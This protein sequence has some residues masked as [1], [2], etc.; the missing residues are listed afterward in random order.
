MEKVLVVGYFG[1]T[2]MMTATTIAITEK[3]INANHVAR[4]VLTGKDS[5]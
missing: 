2:A 1:F 3:T 4:R 5:S